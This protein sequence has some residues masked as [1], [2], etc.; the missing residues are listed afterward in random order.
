MGMWEL[1]LS[2]LGPGNG[3]KSKHL[4]QSFIRAHEPCDSAVA[5]KQILHLGNSGGLCFQLRSRKE[6]S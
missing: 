3:I 5:V 2:T 6:V 4:T 1:T